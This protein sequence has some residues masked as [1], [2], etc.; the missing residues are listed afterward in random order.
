MVTSPASGGLMW[1]TGRLE[2]ADELDVAGHEVRSF[3]SS[4]YFFIL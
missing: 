3:R 2:K 1:P 4:R